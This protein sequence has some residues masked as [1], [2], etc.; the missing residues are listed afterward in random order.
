MRVAAGLTLLAVALPA[1]D[2]F[3]HMAHIARGHSERAAAMER[4][5]ILDL[6]NPTKILDNVGT[7][8]EG[9]KLPALDLPKLDGIDLSKL[10]QLGQDFDLNK[11]FTEGLDLTKVDQDKLK[12]DLGKLDILKIG[13][14]F[15]LSKIGDF[16]ALN[17]GNNVDVSGV[18]AEV[19][20]LAEGNVTAG[21]GQ[22]A[23]ASGGN[24][25]NG[26]QQLT[27]QTGSFLQQLAGEFKTFNPL[28]MGVF[29][30]QLLAAQTKIR[31]DAKKNPKFTDFPQPQLLNTWQNELTRDMI[32]DAY[33]LH[34]PDNE[35]AWWGG[36]EDEA[37]PY[38]P[39]GP[40]D[41][42]G[43]CPGLNT[44]ANHG[45]LPRNGLVTPYELM[46][47]VWEG[48]SMSP[49]LA[50]LLVF[51][52]FVMKGNLW[53]QKLSLGGGTL[54]SP[55]GVGISDHGFLEGDASVTRGD[56]VVGDQVHLN[57]TRLEKFKA[58]IAQFGDNGDITPEVC[59]ASRERAYQDSR[60]ENP[61]F[62]FNPLRML[63]AYAESGFAMEVF[64]GA[65]RRCTA[66]TIDWF[67][68]KERFPPG[69][70]RR[71]VPLTSGEML[72]WDMLF[73]K[74]RPVQSG[75]NVGGVF[76][77]IPSIPGWTNFLSA[78]TVKMNACSLASMF[79]TLLPAGVISF[80]LGNGIGPVM[81]G[82][83]CW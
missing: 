23:Q 27:Q 52:A 51:S 13:E 7:L 55:G 29:T 69:W 30:L 31:S 33:D 4:D 77:P 17:L 65:H 11:I 12:E 45:Y 58:E 34:R 37:H 46:R 2:A 47:G 19:A 26:L 68:A 25:A 83:T 57:V 80:A 61:S 40:N 50:S 76:V 72:A 53:T 56:K 60:A 70:K 32:Y 39:P 66:E 64:R 67:F 9:F 59:A 28:T 49:E 3:P 44:L 5:G 10:T 62:D 35:D 73:N 8:A 63:V 42:R 43:P 20:T 18:K 1:A 78:G 6:F 79:I 22:I 15:D 21:L 14:K 24:V 54:L 38:Q 71:N 48:Y 16:S 82:L 81:Q 75:Y 74:I 41:Q 36:G